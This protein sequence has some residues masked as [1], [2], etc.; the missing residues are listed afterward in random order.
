M[1]AN[2]NFTQVMHESFR[3]LTGASNPHLQTLLR[4]LVRW[5]VLQAAVVAG[6]LKKPK[7]GWNTV[8]HPGYPPIWKPRRDYSLERT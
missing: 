1:P 5:R 2:V 7:Y 3:P 4:R 6:T 8:F